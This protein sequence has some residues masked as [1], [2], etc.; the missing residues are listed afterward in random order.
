[1][2]SGLDVHGHGRG[3]ICN[4]TGC[5]RHIAMKQ[6]QSR[7]HE[8]MKELRHWFSCFEQYWSFMENLSMGLVGF[9]VL[10]ELH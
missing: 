1:M 10:L 9:V 5:E 3:G 7:M 8:S 4:E 2:G 6:R